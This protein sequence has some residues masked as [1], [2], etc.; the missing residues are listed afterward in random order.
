VALFS[1]GRIL[2][3]GDPE[4]LTQDEP[5]EAA[6]I[7]ARDIDAAQAE[8]VGMTGVIAT[9]VQGRRLRV[10]FEPGALEAVRARIAPTGARVEET[11][12][13]LEETAFVITRRAAG[14]GGRP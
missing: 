1:G 14:V 12:K 13:R 9:A 7:Y 11:S 2:A 5:F 4:T 8:L 3:R 6:L 10:L